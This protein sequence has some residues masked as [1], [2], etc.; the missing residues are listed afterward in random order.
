[1]LLRDAPSALIFFM[2]PLL[3]AS[4]ADALHQP[5]S[6]VESKRDSVQGKTP[7]AIAAENAGSRAEIEPSGAGRLACVLR[8]TIEE[9]S[10]ATIKTAE[11]KFETPSDGRNYKFAFGTKVPVQMTINNT[12]FT[13]LAPLDAV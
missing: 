4:M 11:Y 12:L 7:A 8:L 6:L 3:V 9:G 10:P 13:W 5:S 2:I 1:M